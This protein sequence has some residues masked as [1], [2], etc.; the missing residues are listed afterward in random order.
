MICLFHK[1]WYILWYEM[2]VESSF[3]IQ[4]KWNN[5]G[6]SLVVSLQKE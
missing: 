4:K 3:K 5:W 1:S 2:I 6:V